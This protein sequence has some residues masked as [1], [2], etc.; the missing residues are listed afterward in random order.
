M[1]IPMVFE[2]RGNQKKTELP[3]KVRIA[4]VRWICYG[5]S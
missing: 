1:V 2:E 5:N 4:R 3:G